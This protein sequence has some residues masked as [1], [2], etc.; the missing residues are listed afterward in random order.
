MSNTIIAPDITSEIMHALYAQFPAE[1]EKTMVVSGVEL[2]FVPVS[3]VINRLNR[4]LGIDSWSFEVIKIERDSIETDDI[5][6]HISLTAMINGSRI[7]K[8][9]V[10]GATVKRIKSTGK[11]LDLGNAYKMAVSDALK[12]AAQQ[13]GVGLYLSRSADALDVEEAMEFNYLPETQIDAVDIPVKNTAEKSD[14][15]IRY[16]AFLDIAKKLNKEQKEELNEFWK[17]HS[18][19]KPKPTKTTATLDDLQVLNIEAMRI[20]FG[21]TYVEPNNAGK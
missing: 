15:E 8:H 7:I 18:G 4:V 20:A 6:S 17:N 16:E 14:V 10:G 21:A 2:R 9:G 5:I 12:K 13:L 3:E 11:P 1:M 19:G